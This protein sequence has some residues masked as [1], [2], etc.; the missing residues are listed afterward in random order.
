MIVLHKNAY[1]AW[2]LTL[3]LVVAMVVKLRPSAKLRMVQ[4]LMPGYNIANGEVENSESGVQNV[5]A[6][7]VRLTDLFVLIL[8]LLKNVRKATNGWR[9]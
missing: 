1:T 5:R 9:L 6:D 4:T 7:V 2:V 8:I 3:N